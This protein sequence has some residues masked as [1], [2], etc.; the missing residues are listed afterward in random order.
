[1][2]QHYHSHTALPGSPSAPHP[3][4]VCHKS[5]P[6]QQRNCNFHTH[7]CACIC[8]CIDC[9]HHW[10]TILC[11]C[12]DWLC[13]AIPTCDMCFIVLKLKK[14]H[15]PHTQYQTVQIRSDPTPMGPLGGITTTT[16]AVYMCTC[17]VLLLVVLIHIQ[18]TTGSIHIHI[19]MSIY[20]ICPHL[21][22]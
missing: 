15:T 9:T 3:T 16:T 22:I 5:P 18:L 11:K 4:R 21:P 1:V 13:K 2:V 19:H 14:T 8:I 17:Q 6:K 12:P 20:A 10:M 7:G